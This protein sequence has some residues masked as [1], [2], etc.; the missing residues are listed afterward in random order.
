MKN[1]INSRDA[2]IKTYSSA[3]VNLQISIEKSKTKSVGH[4]QVKKIEQGLGSKHR[5]L[6]GSNKPKSSKPSQRNKADK[7]SA[8]NNKKSASRPKNTCSD[9][10]QIPVKRGIFGRQKLTKNSHLKAASIQHIFLRRKDLNKS[11]HS[12]R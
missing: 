11:R 2:I 4:R 3:K 10:K 8:A 7:K 12:K 1:D 6:S 5:R 9:S